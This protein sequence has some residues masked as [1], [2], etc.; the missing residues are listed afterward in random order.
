MR[1]HSCESG[2]IINF[3]YLKNNKMKTDSDGMVYVH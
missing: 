1:K 2:I 3:A